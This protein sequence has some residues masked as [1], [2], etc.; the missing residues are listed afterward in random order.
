MKLV[1]KECLIK[2]IIDSGIINSLNPP[3]PGADTRTLPISPER[4]V[5][6]CDVL[7]MTRKRYVVPNRIELGETVQNNAPFIE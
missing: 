1:G 6:L 5:S 2:T 3:P 7:S 4:L